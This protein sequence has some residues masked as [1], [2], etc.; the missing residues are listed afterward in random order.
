[1]K[2]KL[3]DEQRANMDLAFASLDKLRKD[4]QFMKLLVTLTANDF[5]EDKHVNAE[6][7]KDYMDIVNLYQNLSDYAATYFNTYE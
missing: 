7:E 3:T 1:M 4:K 2:I 6:N 5:D